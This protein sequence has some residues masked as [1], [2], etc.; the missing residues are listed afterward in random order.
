METSFQNDEIALADLPDFEAVSFQMVSPKLLWASLLRMSVVFLLLGVGAV[1]LYYNVT[2]RQPIVYG[3][4]G[5]VVLFVI[6]CIRIWCRQAHYGYALREHDIQYKRGFLSI[7]TTVIPY[8]RIQHSAVNESFYDK[9]FGLASWQIYTAGGS[10]SDISIPG[11]T[12]E[13]AKQLSVL[14]SDKTTT[15]EG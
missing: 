5:L 11:L 2:P 1:V 13:L 3:G 14:L 8:S 10:G 12:P 9:F 6:N 4:V 15:Y 7:K